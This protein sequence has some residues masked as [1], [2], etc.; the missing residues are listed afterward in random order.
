[1]NFDETFSREQILTDENIPVLNKLKNEVIKS[2]IEKLL[3]K[4]KETGADFLR[5][6]EAAAMRHPNK[7]HLIRDDWSDIFGDLE[8]D[9][10][11][12]TTIKRYFNVNVNVNGNVN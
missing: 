8:Y 9:I 1:V 4:S 11:V 12:G 7:Y 5:L 2:E 3:E 6:G 10:R